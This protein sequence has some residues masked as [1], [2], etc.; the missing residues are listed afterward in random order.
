MGVTL[1]R[2]AVAGFGLLLILGALG[3]AVAAGPAALLPAAVTFC[4]GAVLLVGAAIER[5]RYRSTTAERHGQ[6]PGPGGGEP[7]GAPIE[8][9]FQATAEVFVDPTTHVR[10]RVLVDS[11]TGERRYVADG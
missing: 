6:P 8:P 3:I 4:V 9:R 11:R 7:A 2:A 5:I 10:M 1:A